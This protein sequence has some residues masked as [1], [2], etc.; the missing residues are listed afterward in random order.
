M[1]P[2]KIIGVG[3]ILM[4][5]VLVGIGLWQTAGARTNG[6]IAIVCQ[7]QAVMGTTCTLAAVV[8]YQRRA[9]AEQTLRRAETAL[10]TIEVRMSTWLTDSEIS[11]FNAAQPDEEVHLSAGSLE[12]LRAAKEAWTQTGGA[13]DVT[14]RPLIEL[15]RRAGDEG[16]LPTESEMSGARAASNWKLIELR[17]TGAVK[18]AAGAGVDLGGIAK[19]YAIDRAIEVLRSGEV[20]GGMV[21]VGGDLACFGRQPDARL[22]PVDVKSPFGSGRLAQLRIPGGAVATSGNYAR[23]AQIAGKRYSHI[24]DPRTGRPAEAAQSATVVAPSAMAADIWATALSVLGREGLSRL[25]ENVEA[26]IVVGSE[27]DCQVICTAGM[28]DL[29]DEPLPE[30]LTVW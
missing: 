10:R 19:G 2:G 29:L 22:W 4:L 8:P 14:C 13:F 5:I 11:R 12:I 21:D 25:P 15:W 6:R 17:E 23:Y 27:N 28:R 26:L 7:P 16:V 30:Q 1:R 20:A 9:R 3:L 24:I 18:R